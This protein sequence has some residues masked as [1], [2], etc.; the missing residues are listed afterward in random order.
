MV[1]PRSARASGRSLRSTRVTPS[2]R[3][4]STASG[5]GS[6]SA[7]GAIRRNAKQLDRGAIVMGDVALDVAH[8]QRDGQ[9]ADHRLEQRLLFEQLGGQLLALADVAQDTRPANCG[10]PAV[11]HQGC[12]RAHPHDASVA[13][14]VA[15]LEI[16]VIDLAVP[17]PLELRCGLERVFGVRQLA[18]RL[19]SRSPA[20]KPQQEQKAALQRRKRPSRSAYAMPMG[21]WSNVLWNSVSALCSSPR[22]VKRS[23]KSLMLPTKPVSLPAGTTR[24]AK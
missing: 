22:A 18:A 13:A 8:Q 1:S 19:P 9:F 4:T 14:Q 10:S 16:Y 15:L 23:V 24:S 17:Q 11:A 6:T 3:Y 2:M 12:R 21:A 5:Y 7:V 20:V